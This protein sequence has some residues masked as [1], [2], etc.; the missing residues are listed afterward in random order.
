MMPAALNLDSQHLG[1]TVKS[2]RDGG[3]GWT[4]KQMSAADP[5]PKDQASFESLLRALPNRMS[6]IPL[7]L[8]FLGFSHESYS[9]FE[10]VPGLQSLRLGRSEDLRWLLW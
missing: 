5:G 9:N 8:A 10:S 2:C 6:S 3:G 4:T 7:Q 1:G